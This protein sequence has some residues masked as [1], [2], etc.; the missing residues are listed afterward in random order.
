MMWFW[1]GDQLERLG[2]FLAKHGLCGPTVTA[3]GVS[4]AI[5]AGMPSLSR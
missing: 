2:A 5:R 1:S 4:I 3:D